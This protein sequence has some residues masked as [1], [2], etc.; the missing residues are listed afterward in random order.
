[1]GQLLLIPE[2]FAA[3]QA[4]MLVHSFSPTHTGFV[5]YTEFL[6]LFGQ[7][8]TVGTVQKVRTL[9]DVELYFSWTVGT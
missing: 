9:G 2:R 6:E 4:V 1:M 7:K 5:D 3:R 8:A